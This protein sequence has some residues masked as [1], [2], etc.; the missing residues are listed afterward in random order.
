MATGPEKQGAGARWQT[1]GKVLNSHPLQALYPPSPLTTKLEASPR[2]QE[3][4]EKI[5]FKT[6]CLKALMSSQNSE[7]YRLRKKRQQK[8][9]DKPCIW[10]HPALL[11]AERN[12]GPWRQEG[13]LGP[14][15]SLN[16]NIYLSETTEKMWQ[17]T[18]KWVKLDRENSLYLS[19]TFYK[20]EIISKS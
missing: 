4:L 5:F 11:K 10:G 18:D 8:P 7:G 15:C 9:R 14:P 1:G 3:K 17:N 20:F 19:S 2:Q 16:M 13:L 6:M 12:P